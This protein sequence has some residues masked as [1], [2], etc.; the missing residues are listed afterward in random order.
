MKAEKSTIQ[1]LAELPIYQE[2]AHGRAVCSDTKSRCTLA[3]KLVFL[4]LLLTVTTLGKNPFNAK[5][6]FVAG[7][8]DRKMLPLLT[9]NSKKCQ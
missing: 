1:P 4:I 3:S 6:Q 5:L 7:H 9:D 2:Y 8:E